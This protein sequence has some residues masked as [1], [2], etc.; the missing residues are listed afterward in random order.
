MAKKRRKIKRVV[1]R[2]PEGLSREESRQKNH[3]AFIE[4][5]QRR[6]KYLTIGICVAVLAV[7]FFILSALGVFDKKASTTTLTLKE[8][9]TV[10]FEEIVE[11]DSK[12]SK[13]D[14]KDYAKQTIDEY[15]RTHGS[16][17][18]KL[19][20]VSTKG[21]N[22]Y[23]KTTYKDAKCY[24][25]FTSYEFF[26]GTIQSAQDAGYVFDGT[27]SAVKKGKKKDTVEVSKVTK[28]AS[29]NVVIIDQ[30]ISVVVPDDIKYVS[31]TF[32]ETVGRKVNI[33]G[34][35]MTYIVY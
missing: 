31:E 14:V 13:G 5:I 23:L 32:T 2:T 35:V 18:V 30:G 7:I 12:T 27:F 24:S 6:R 28:D 34:D 10:V 15:N 22:I 17:L 1:P 8:D 16:G 20:K 9:G 3:E 11:V 21:K 19:N 26:V 33:S 29:A 25:D 4:T